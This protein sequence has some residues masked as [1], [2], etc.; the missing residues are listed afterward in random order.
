[1]C[2]FCCCCLVFFASCLHLAGPH[3]MLSLS[4]PVHPAAARASR[5]SLWQALPAPCPPVSP[6][7]DLGQPCHVF[8]AACRSCRSSQT[9]R[10]VSAATETRVSVLASRRLREKPR[11]SAKEQQEQVMGAQRP[12]FPHQEGV[13][14]VLHAGQASSGRLVDAGRG[15][16]RAA[17]QP[18]LPCSGSSGC[19]LVLPF[20]A[21][22]KEPCQAPA[23]SHRSLR[24]VRHC[25]LCIAGQNDFLVEA[26][27]GR[28]REQNARSLPAR[29]P[30]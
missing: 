14:L 6:V 22:F 9:Q 3:A 21:G 7:R 12:L 26:S 18:C 25:S 19:S 23:R 29:A 8:V 17:G 13:R 30:L 11:C 4:R 15:S 27:W 1:M 28:L 10:C 5:G 24:S 16:Q 2:F 20:T